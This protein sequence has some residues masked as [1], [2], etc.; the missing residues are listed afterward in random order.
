MN[1]APLLLS[2]YFH[3]NPRKLLGSKQSKMQQQVPYNAYHTQQQQQ[4]YA[5]YP[6]PQQLQFAS[7]AGYP[8][9]QPIYTAYP[10]AQ[11]PALTVISVPS[12]QPQ[13]IV[14]NN[15]QGDGKN[16]LNS[17]TSRLQST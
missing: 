16:F 5:Q 9:Q 6:Q 4:Q 11:A 15:D 3:I 1:T 7:P 13:V 10:Q 8:Q 2:S 14:V 12:A 17:F